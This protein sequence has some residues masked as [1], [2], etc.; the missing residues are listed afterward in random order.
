MRHYITSFARC[1][2][3]VTALTIAVQTVPAENWPQF[4]GPRADGIS[5]EKNPPI[6]WSATDN[7]RWKTPIPGEGHS[8]PVI[9][10]SSVFLTSAAKESGHRD[11]LRLDAATGK[12]LW[13][14]TVTTA[15][16]EAMHR[17]NSSASSTPATD[18][19]SVFAVFQAGDRV[20]LS[21]LD[22]DGNQ[23]WS[24]QPLQFNGEHGFS[25]SPILHGDLLL[26][27]CRQ[28]GEA[29]F[30]AVEK[31]TGKIR[32]RAKPG[33]NR[34]SHLSPLVVQQGGRSQVVVCGSDEIRSYE[35]T[36]GRELWFCRG[37]S[38]VAVAGLSYGDGVVFA[39]AGYPARV[40]MAVRVSGSGDV[41]DSHVVWSSR[42]QVTYVPSPV[43]HD[44][45]L[46]T[47]IDEGIM[48]CLNAKS[49]E[50]V[51]EQRVGG[52][53]RSSLV[54]ADG[55]VYATNDQGLTTFFEASS[56][57]FSPVAKNDLKELCYATPA[58][59]SG[60]IYLRTGANLYCIEAAQ[61]Q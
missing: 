50:A 21:A 3:I 30:L 26:L 28:E 35:P 8:S 54:L 42:K 55:N 60:R 57:G 25:Y 11:L 44:G 24:I 4:R 7:V 17:E 5:S 16:I 29:A 59:S 56:K 46:Y 52:R 33:K 61:A 47:A 6:Q 39:T 23:L 10:G 13:Q 40:R 18:G 9:W 20:A 1:S 43:Y 32:W 12:V 19:Q 14:K 2:G 34:I 31:S 37:P 53:F 51:W 58:I 48:V 15:P 49:G 22:F 36:S 41:T 38:D 45:H 27:D